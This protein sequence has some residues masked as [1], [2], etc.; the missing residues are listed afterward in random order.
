MHRTIPSIFELRN[1]KNNNKR[2][3]MIRI[4]IML[5]ISIPTT[6]NGKHELIDSSIIF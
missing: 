1:N 5:C 2:N 6:V 3:N 4:I